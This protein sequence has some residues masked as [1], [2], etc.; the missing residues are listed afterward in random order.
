[1]NKFQ[2]QIVK[3]EFAR[4]AMIKTAKESLSESSFRGFLS[5]PKLY[6]ARR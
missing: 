2:K 3:E 5:S 1:M 6:Q 4:A